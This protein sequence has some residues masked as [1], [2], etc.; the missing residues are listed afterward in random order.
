V[1]NVLEYD[2]RILRRFVNFMNN[3]DE[4]TAVEQFGKEGKYFGACVLLITMPGLPMIGHG[5]IEGFHEKY[6][7][8]YRRAYWDEPEDRHLV[9]RHEAQIFP[10]MRHRRLFSGSENFVFYDFFS[11][12]QV[13][14]NVFAY[15]NEAGGERGLILYHNRYAATSGWIRTSTAIAGKNDSGDAILIRKTL[16]EALDLNPDGRYY[17]TCRDYA[18]GLEYLHSGQKLCN[19]GLYAELGCYEFKAFLDFREICDDEFGSWGKLCAILHGRGVAS[20][21]EELKQVRHGAVIEAF[22]LA[23]GATA[24]ILAAPAGKDEKER[25]QARLEDLY[26]EL[27][28][29]TGCSGDYKTLAGEVL[30]EIVAVGALNI[31]SEQ[32][33]LDELGSLTGTPLDWLLLAAFLVFHSSGRLAAVEEHSLVAASWL[34]ELGLERAFKE[35]VA[36]ASRGEGSGQ[37]EGIAFLLRPLIRMQR[38]LARWQLNDAHARFTLL[39]SDPGVR[40]Y[41]CVHTYEESEWFNRERF[42]T[43]L[44]WLLTV[45]ALRLANPKAPEQF[46]NEIAPLRKEFHHLRMVAAEAGFRLDRFLDMLKAGSSGARDK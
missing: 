21:A 2:H 36:E 28:R 6:G 3:P 29:H 13:D 4:R 24:R 18:G 14:E 41:L 10:L 40:E 30:L 35:D 1:K 22:R 31:I 26:G 27:N 5:Q 34:G 16:G 42:E 32:G 44:E 25:L 12:E 46:S 7:M 9:A 20:L 11:G 39:F 33:E 37:G 43:L 17:Y 19:D 8:E 15:S 45:E 23:V 38:F